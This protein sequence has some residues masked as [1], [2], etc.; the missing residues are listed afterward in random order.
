VGRRFI[1]PLLKLFVEGNSGPVE[2]IGEEEFLE[3]MLVWEKEDERDEPH[4]S[5]EVPEPNDKDVRVE[6]KVEED[7]IT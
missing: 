4:E 5:V 1:F 7:L 2:I 3:Q 6:A